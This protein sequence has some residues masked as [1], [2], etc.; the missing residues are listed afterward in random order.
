[1]LL[2]ATAAL[3]HLLI[4][5][6]FILGPLALD[7]TDPRATGAL[8][9]VTVGIA[10]LAPWIARGVDRFVDG[11]ILR[12]PDY[13]RVKSVVAQRLAELETPA[14]ILNATV[15][16]LK[17]ALCARSVTWSE[18]SEAHA[19]PSAAIIVETSYGAQR[20]N[21]K[22]MP[23]EPP[24]FTLQVSQLE[25]GR[26]VLSDDL[27]L[28][29]SVAQ[30]AA[31]RID[32]VRATQVRFAHAMRENEIL[33]LA[34]EAE[35]RSLKAQLNP[36]FLFN[37]LT[38]IGFLMQEAP[39]RALETL[40]SLTDLLRAVLR[41]TDGDFTTVSEELDIVASYLAIEKARFEERLTISIE[42]A[43]DLLDYQIPALVLQ[44]LVE[45]AVK[46][47]IASKAEGGAVTISGRLD[48]DM[49]GLTSLVLTV[50]DS[51]VG[52]SDFVLH[53]RASESVGL[54]NIERRLDTYFG[55]RGGLLIQSVVGAGTRAE[56]WMPAVTGRGNTMALTESA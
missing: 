19:D 16:A 7:N 48:S 40:Y 41:R 22:V 37:A 2:V 17:P 32:S 12:R 44:P 15:G 1:M 30:L 14:D 5:A 28:L 9:A 4:T 56:L 51:G 39:S 53:N 20:V 29:E 52:T 33:Q 18:S 35:L 6:P 13:R 11:V 27:T 3:A 21:V 31:H 49:A 24:G 8:L 38:T 45:N 43:D 36:H 47:G 23:A 54:N 55:K 50:V 10:L 26:R 46:H 34:T 42:I 25:G